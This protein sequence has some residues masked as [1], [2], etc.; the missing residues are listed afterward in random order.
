MDQNVHNITSAQGLI[1]TYLV[2][3][4]NCTLFGLRG[5]DEHRHLLCEQFT[6]DNNKTGR[7]LR[8][9]GRSSK[10]VIGGLHQKNIAVKDL[11]ICDCLWENR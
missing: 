11:K 2:F 1:M 3:F 5:G 6:V 9:M 4:Y 10:N 8:F 7:Y